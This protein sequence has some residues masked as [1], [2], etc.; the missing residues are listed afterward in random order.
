MR[1]V[2]P[3]ASLVLLALA[4][5]AA[6]TAAE[7]AARTPRSQD[8]HY[9]WRLEGV[10]G[11]LSRLLGLLP[12]TG[13]AV[14]ALRVVPDD[15]L[16]VA[17]TASSEKADAG[18][19]WKYET[20]VD[21]GAWQSLSV[22]ET[23]H[24]RKKN[25][26]ES[27]ELAEFGVLDV[28]S[29][30]Q[31]MRFAPPAESE[32]RTIWSGGKLY[33]VAITMVGFERLEYDGRAVT[34]RHLKIHGLKEPQQRYW[35]SRAEL[36]LTDDEAALPVELLFHQALGRLRLSLVGASVAGALRPGG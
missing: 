24:Y 26:S 31:L 8:L 34:V 27:F 23:L 36:W 28:L 7:P 1:S 15:R 18:D 3:V 30:L 35:K 14:M 10:S 20:V 12:T 32:R 17:F 19:Y 33:P 9:R 2:L 13:D 16:E 22:R 29:G 21:L 11:V 25:K 4:G 5:S 6:A